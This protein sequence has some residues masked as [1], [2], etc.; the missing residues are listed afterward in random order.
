MFRP[1]TKVHKLTKRVG[2]ASPTGKVVSVHGEHVEVKWDDGH[3]SVIT[4]DGLAEVK[5]D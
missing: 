3:T 2:Q 1:G 5:K 4:K